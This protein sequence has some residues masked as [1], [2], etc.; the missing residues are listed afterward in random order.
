MPKRRFV[1]LDRDGTIIV[2]RHY[3]S[4][5]DQITLTEGAIEGLTYL[6]KL[7]FGLIIVTNQSAIARGFFNIETLDAIHERLK[8]ILRSHDIEIDGIY[9]CPHHPNDGCACRK[10]EP[11]LLNIASIEFDFDTKDCFVIGDNVSDIELG[12]RIQAQTIL[13]KTGYGKTVSDNTLT[14]PDYT[15]ANLHDAAQIIGTLA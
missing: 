9:Y 10:P 15:V 4:D 6:A 14:H 11:G 3:L 12:K 8:E 5:P 7:G 1:I 2:E 13:V